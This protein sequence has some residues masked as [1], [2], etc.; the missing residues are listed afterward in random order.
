MNL[1]VASKSDLKSNPYL[2]LSIILLIGFL[3]RI[4]LSTVITFENDF[5]IWQWW[6]E[7]LSKVGFSNFYSNYWCDY[8]PGYLYI[9]RLLTDIQNEFT[10]LSPYILFKLP[11]NLSDLG[12]S[13]LIFVFLKPISSTRI[14][15]ISSLAYFFN[16]AVLSNSTFWGQVDSVHAFPI[17]LAIILGLRK[18]FVLSGLFAA[19]AFMIKP[20]SIVLF[21]II[22]FIAIE[23]FFRSENRWNIKN[24]IPGT[25]VII[26]VIV[27][28]VVITLPFIWDKIDSIFYLLTGPLE[29]IKE[30][31][32]KA[33]EQYKFA[34]LNTFNF[35]GIFA[36]WVSDETVFLGLTFK[37]WGTIIFGTIYA[38]IFAFFFRFKILRNNSKQEY[39]YL[40][41]QAVTLILFSLF[42]FVTRAHERHLLPSIVFFT[43]IIF[44]SWIFP[45]LYAI[46][47][48]VY[49]C[50]MIYSYIQLTT[51][52]TGVPDS[53]ERILI[54]AMF[55]LYFGAFA[56]VLLNFFRHTMREGNILKT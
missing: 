35:W 36:M 10:G 25:K 3:L 47:S 20:Q 8:M 21:P 34:S 31:F 7:G 55:A 56:I 42:L 45:Y 43:L 11:A 49:V 18:K 5:K 33:Y 38:L 51:E 2:Q 40:I 12:I 29:L 16:P 13:I 22:G 17:L 1:E 28:C 6:G 4:Y 14:A 24:F 26:T 39:T 32:D 44:R 54:P 50:N 30:R 46:V 23:P 53:I 41:F 52:Y 9:L 27:T 15:M 48:G 19:L 37:T